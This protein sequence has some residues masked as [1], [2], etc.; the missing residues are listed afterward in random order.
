MTSIQTASV[1]LKDRYYIYRRLVL[2]QRTSAAED[3]QLYWNLKGAVVVTLAAPKL[4]N[5]PET[6]LA[7]LSTWYDVLPSTVYPLPAR[8]QPTILQISLS[9]HFLWTANTGSQTLCDWTLDGGTHYRRTFHTIVD[10]VDDSSVN[11]CDLS[12]ALEVSG[13]QPQ[14]NIKA[15][16]CTG[17]LGMKV[18]G[19]QSTGWPGLQSYVL[20]TDLGP[21]PAP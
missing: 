16:Q 11:E 14:V 17:V 2:H 10:R 1:P 8:E 15:R 7:A 19:T 5:L 9:A 12:F 13:T 6:S 18:I 20:I 3:D 21:L 4:I